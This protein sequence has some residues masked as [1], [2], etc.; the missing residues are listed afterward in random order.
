MS[1][2]YT[3]IVHYTSWKFSHILRMNEDKHD[4]LVED[5]GENQCV[6]GHNSIQQEAYFLKVFT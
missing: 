4:D 6:L 1:Y 5:T 2:V 3:H